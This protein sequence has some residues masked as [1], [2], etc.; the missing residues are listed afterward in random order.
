[1]A[2]EPVL[3]ICVPS[4]NRQEYFQATIIDLLR[5]SRGDVEFVFADNSDDPD[6]M[7]G[8]MADYLDDPRMTYLPSADSVLSMTDNWERTIARARGRWVTFVGDDDYADPELAGVLTELERRAGRVDAL[9]WNPVNYFWPEAGR[10]PRTV[11][12]GLSNQLTRMHRQELMARSFGWQGATQMPRSGSSVYHGAVSRSLLETIRDRCGGRFFETPIVDFEMACK[13]IMMG[14][15]FF[16]AERPFSVGG[17]CPKSNSASFKTI[18]DKDKAL[19]QFMAEQRQNWFRNPLLGETAFSERP[20]VPASILL[21][22]QWIAARYGVEHEG[23]EANFVAALAFECSLNRD[24]QSFDAVAGRTRSQLANWRDG[25]YLH[26]FNPV[27]SDAPLDPQTN[28]ILWY[29]L[30]SDAGVLSFPGNAA[31]V[32]TAG[33]LYGLIQS[34]IPLP[35]EL[36][37]RI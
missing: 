15:A 19:D 9:S 18:R 6:V 23:Y 21:V 16:L 10:P 32:A 28:G 37:F 33:E 30:R 2:A 35:A 29:G 13:V 20:G 11:S 36:D 3:S 25:R 31:D 17:V 14:K 12:L 5:S 22:Q 1:M 7:N 4:R 27:Y 24:R 8:F 34:L 26:L